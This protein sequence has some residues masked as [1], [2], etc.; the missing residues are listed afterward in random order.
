MLDY[1]PKEQFS[2]D[3]LGDIA[4]ETPIADD[5][6]SADL[7]NSAL[8]RSFLATSERDK[9]GDEEGRRHY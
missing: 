4:P 3:I 1:I 8:P 6:P 7:I 2:C 9:R 5:A